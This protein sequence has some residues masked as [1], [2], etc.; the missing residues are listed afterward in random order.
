[1]K[2]TY[3]FILVISLSDIVLV[4]HVKWIPT[5]KDGLVENLCF[6]VSVELF[7]RHPIDVHL[8]C[9]LEAFLLHPGAT[10]TKELDLFSA[11]SFDVL[12]NFRSNQI[13]LARVCQ[14]ANGLDIRCRKIS[15]ASLVHFL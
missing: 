7:G 4:N 11:Y 8:K 13:S 10:V 5:E 2:N 15:F 9:V 12:D 14:D 1:M 3:N 6:T